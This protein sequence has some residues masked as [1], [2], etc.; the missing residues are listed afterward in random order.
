MVSAEAHARA[1]QILDDYFAAWREADAEVRSR[2]L[3]DCASPAVEF[4]D[5][6]ACVSGIDELAA[7][8]TAALRHMPGMSLARDGDVSQCQGSGVVDWVA[9]APDGKVVA[10]GTNVVEFAPDGRLR[11]MTGLWKSLAPA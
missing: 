9:T 1:S 4:R 8:V 5:R 11:C 10:R 7:H 6:F 2:L 3:R